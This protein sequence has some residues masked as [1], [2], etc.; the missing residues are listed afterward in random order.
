MIVNQDI[1]HYLFF[2]IFIIKNLVYIGYFPLINDRQCHYID[3]S[4]NKIPETLDFLILIDLR[5][6]FLIKSNRFLL[7]YL[8]IFLH[9]CYINNY[10]KAFI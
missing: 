10:I 5:F 6:I 9:Y 4:L 1:Y 8:S 7:N 2:I 3:N